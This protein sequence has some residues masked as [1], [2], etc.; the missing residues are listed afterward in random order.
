MQ[1]PQRPEKG[2]RS[3][4]TKVAGDYEPPDVGA[5]S[6]TGGVCRNRAQFQSRGHFSR[7]I[8]IYFNLHSIFMYGN[9]LLTE[10]PYPSMEGKE[11]RHHYRQQIASSPLQCK[12]STLR[13]FCSIL[14]RIFYHCVMLIM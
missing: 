3:P 8:P 6:Q 12:Y 7:P 10:T 9:G 13:Y 2:I 1:C 14:Q 4:R 11:F 5:A